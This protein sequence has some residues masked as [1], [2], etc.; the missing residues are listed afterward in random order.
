[1][2]GTSTPCPLIVTAWTLAP[3]AWRIPRSIA[4]RPS[5]KF[6]ARCSKTPEVRNIQSIFA[7]CLALWRGRQ[8]LML[9]PGTTRTEWQSW[10]PLVEWR[11]QEF[12]RC[13]KDCV[14]RALR[15][16]EQDGATSGG[17]EHTKGGVFLH[18]R[19]TPLFGFTPRGGCGHGVRCQANP[20]PRCDPRTSS[21]RSRPRSS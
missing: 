7:S 14:I 16:S 21:L 13:R 2:P 10:L 18:V 9:D 6:I 5:S 1:M 20:A 17:P 4:V 11:S 3:G 12:Q 15:L 19:M 8:V